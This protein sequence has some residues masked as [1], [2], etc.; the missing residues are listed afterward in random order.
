MQNS[1]PTCWTKYCPQSS[2]WCHSMMINLAQIDC[3]VHCN[4]NKIQRN[5]KIL[6]LMAMMECI[7]TKSS[8][9]WHNS[10]NHSILLPPFCELVVCSPQIR[11]SVLQYFQNVTVNRSI[12]PQPWGQYY[13]NNRKEWQSCVLPQACLSHCALHEKKFENIVLHCWYFFK[14][15]WKYQ[16]AKQMMVW[17]AVSCWSSHMSN[18]QSLSPV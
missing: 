1:H 7:C 2:I 6:I 12:Q 5:Q 15:E 4:I 10:R 9:P 17:N 13:P 11:G 14:G 16:T 3:V 8:L 18:D